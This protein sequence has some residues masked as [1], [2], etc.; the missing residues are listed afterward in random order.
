MKLFSLITT[1]NYGQLI[2]VVTFVLILFILFNHQTSYALTKD[3][4]GLSVDQIRWLEEN[5]EIRFAF[6][7]AFAPV[8]FLTD[9][10]LYRGMS[11]DYIEILENL[12]EVKFVMVKT[13]SW[14]PS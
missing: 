6:D 13:S 3:D 11:A 12:L 2:R 4:L 9:D 7:Q 5:P 10:D 8:E 14:H 1:A